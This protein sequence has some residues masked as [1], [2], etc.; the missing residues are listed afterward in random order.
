MRLEPVSIT[1]SA[2]APKIAA[3]A[4]PTARS[5]MHDARTMGLGLATEAVVAHPECGSVCL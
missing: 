3:P 1:E 2:A 4:T 5:S